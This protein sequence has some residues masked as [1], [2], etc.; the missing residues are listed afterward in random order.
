MTY[1]LIANTGIHMTAFSMKLNL[2]DNFK[3]WF[4]E[5]YDQ[6]S[7]QWMLEL[8]HEV[9]T[10]SGDAF[11]YRKKDLFE[12]GYL[13][14]ST[15]RGDIDP[16]QL[17]DDCIEPL[18]SNGEMQVDGELLK[19]T[20]SDRS[21]QLSKL[22][23][24]WLPLP[25]FFKLSQRAFKFGPVNWSRFK[26]IPK[27][28]NTDSTRSYLVLLAFDTRAEYEGDEYKEMPVFPNSA[29]LSMNFELCSHEFMLM[30][31][32]SPNSRWNY[33]NNYLFKLVHPELASIEQIHTERKLDYIETYI[34]LIDFI[35][36][37]NLF[38]QVELFKDHNVEVKD[39]DMAIDIGNS[40][41]TALLVEDN[42]SF[43]QVTPLEL[44]DYSHIFEDN[45]D[46]PVFN[47]YKEPFDMRLAFRKVDF[48]NIGIK[49][50][51]QFVYPSFVRLGHEANELIHKATEDDY[52]TRKLSTHS[53]PKRYLWDNHRNKQEWKFM[54]LPDEKDDHILNLPGVS[55]YLKSDGSFTSEGNGGQSYHYSPRSLMT[56]AFLEM[57]CQAQRQINGE[58]YRIARGEKTM[59]RKIRRLIVT[60]PTAMSKVERE[61]LVKCASEAVR[62]L[63]LFNHEP[64][65]RVDVVPG[66]PSFRDEDTHWYYD[67]ATCSQLVYIYGEVGYK[68]RGACQE[69]FNLYGKKTNDHEQPTLT[70]GSIDIGAGT[71]DLMIC[72]Y[73]FTKGDVTTITPDPQ[74]YDSFYF[75]GDDMLKEMVKK[76]MFFADN[77]ALRQRIDYTNEQDYDRRL[78]DFFG[79]DHAGQTYADR[80]LRRDFNLQYSVPL[81][82]YYLELLNKRS[83]DCIVHYSDVFS[84]FEP[85]ERVC[86]GFRDHF[87][88]DIKDL[89]WEF[90]PEDV[91][92]VVTSTLEPLLKKI[93][94]IMHSFNC[95]IVLLTGRPASLYP[96]RDIFLKYYAVSPNRLILLNNYFVGHWYPFTHNTGYITNP[97]TIVAMGAL[98]GYYASTLG[99]LDAFYIDKSKLDAHLKSVINYIE[100]SREGLP[101][102]YFITPEKSSGKLMVSSLPTVLNV[103]Q[104]G[105]DTYP[106]R[107]LYTVDFNRYK[108]ADKL[109]RKAISV[110]DSLNDAQIQ[111]QVKSQIDDMRLKMPF[112]LQ[113]ER[114]PEDKEHLILTQ[115]SDKDGNDIAESNV[116]IN[117]QSLG[118]D[119]RYWLD[120]GAFDIL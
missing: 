90:K 22:E 84:E 87:G 120:T 118:A 54:V 80:M 29:Q 10:E 4:H 75:A 98:I 1:T 62:L 9:V 104:L 94:T 64:D 35:A 46:V 25:Y 20:F 5:W 39:V 34:H 68:Y 78:R 103:R 18:Q 109:R 89:E 76:L 11:M 47:T 55:E 108:M 115:I 12:G 96:V 49:D 97:K 83:K 82:N 65:R 73:D 63:K 19:M 21:N 57:L 59:P 112:H 70:I 61:S 107:N 119:D 86:I 33:I 38:P 110:G 72:R 43:N 36:Q 14:E 85:N 53:S 28:D 95:D 77:S 7:G 37:N 74:F 101:I 27:T 117:I 113:I 88:F 106:S 13:I 92:R 42:A 81:M 100:A 79:P 16:A 2:Q 102:E 23:N 24:K 91:A 48:G 45:T 41:T 58:P 30:D 51:H 56:L 93:A 17:H 111:Q 69:F 71:S 66:P 3:L 6:P 26:L 116:E 50:S 32:C 60:C 105:L 15:G 67:E 52:G 44:Q 8:A 31:F 114:D 99:N 40:R